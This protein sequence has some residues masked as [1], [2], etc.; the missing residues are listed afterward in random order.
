SDRQHAEQ[1]S[2][3]GE[4][5]VAIIPP[6]TA[7]TQGINSRFDASTAHTS[8]IHGA[9]RA[10][11]ESKRTSRCKI[12]PDAM[13]PASSLASNPRP[14]GRWHWDWRHARVTP[15]PGFPHRLSLTSHLG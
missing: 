3:N 4:A 12:A 15:C 1:N 8:A 14:T 10:G 5:H 13:G 7:L 9:G 2:H 6:R 11:G